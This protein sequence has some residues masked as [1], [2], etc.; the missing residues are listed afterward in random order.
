MENKINIIQN[1]NKMIN[2]NEINKN[3]LFFIFLS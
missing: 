1:L 2:I 3:Y